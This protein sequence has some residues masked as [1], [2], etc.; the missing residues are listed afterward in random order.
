MA[1]P[2]A[3]GA[4]NRPPTDRTVIRIDYSAPNDPHVHFPAGNRVLGAGA[5]RKSQILGAG[6]FWTE[7]RPREKSFNWRVGVCGDLKTGKQAHR[8][9]GEFYHGGKIVRTLKAGTNE[10]FVINVGAH[11]NGFF[12]FHL[13]DMSKC[14]GEISSKCFKEGKC[15]QLKRARNP[16]CDS[17]LSKECAPSDPKYPG[18]WYVPLSKEFMALVSHAC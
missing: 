13:C 12:E 18:R 10:N 7:F 17:G 5:G 14:D 1:D 6:K 2:L 4:L 9:G 11:H 15:V 16:K 8:R 3:R